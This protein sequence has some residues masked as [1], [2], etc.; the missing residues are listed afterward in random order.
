MALVRHKYNELAAILALSHNLGILALPSAEK[1]IEIAHAS[2]SCE[3]T[4][5]V[6]IIWTNHRAHFLDAFKFDQ[7][8]H[9]GALICIHWLLG[10]TCEYFSTERCLIEAES[11]LVHELGVVCACAV[12]DVLID[13]FE[14]SFQTFALFGNAEVT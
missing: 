14:N 7:G 4:C 12:R 8:C 13:S 6:L 3:H 10:K 9:R 1:P 2:T 11:E 5:S